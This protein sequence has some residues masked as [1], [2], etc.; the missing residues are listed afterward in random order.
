MSVDLAQV[1]ETTTPAQPND[2]ERHYETMEFKR[3]IQ[4]FRY[5]SPRPTFCIISVGINGCFWTVYRAYLVGKSKSCWMDVQRDESI[6][7]W[8]SG[9]H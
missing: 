3:Y 4:D 9:M 5:F 1:E 2:R 6:D 7:G 8:V